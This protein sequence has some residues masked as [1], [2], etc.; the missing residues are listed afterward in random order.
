[1]GQEPAAGLQ[2]SAYF[3]KLCRRHWRTEFIAG[4]SQTAS[5][6]RTTI[7]AVGDPSLGIPPT[8]TQV[9][10]LSDLNV[11]VSF[12]GLYDAMPRSGDFVQLLENQREFAFLDIPEAGSVAANTLQLDDR[13][14]YDGHIW[15]PIRV[16]NDTGAGYSRCI[17]EMD[18]R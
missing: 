12:P 4:G 10:G 1:M 13:I 14:S 17:A 3:R 7:T 5:I 9:A 11:A 2:G 15:R 18:T 6:I 16:W 8:E